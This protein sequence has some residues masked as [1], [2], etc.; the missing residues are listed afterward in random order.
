MSILYIS[1]DGMLEPLGQSQVLSYL[2]SLSLDYTI[3]LISFEKPHDLLKTVELDN[4]SLDILNSGIIWHRLTYHKSPSVL[5]TLWDIICGASLGLF[6]TIRFDLKIIHSRSYVPSVMALIIKRFTKIKYIFDMRGFWVDER[7][8]GGLWNRKS[9]LFKIAKFF[10]K[11]FLL[12]ADHVVS[13]T[14]AAVYEIENFS[15]L[16]NKT[17]K[18]STI[19]TC[20]NLNL[21][22]IVGN[23][24]TDKSFT[25]G[26][27]GSVGT[28]YL[29]EYVLL[30]FKILLVIMPNARLCIV[31]KG[32]HKYINELLR[33]ESFPEGSI[34]LISSKHIE[35]PLL[36]SQ[37][38]AGIFFI[39]PLFSKQ[40]SAPTKLA[41]FLGC[42]IPC[43]T[44]SGIG[45]M[46]YILESNNV[47]ISISNFDD[48]SIKKGLENLLKL[49]NEAD[50]NKRCRETALNY[51]SLTDGVLAYKKIYDSLLISNNND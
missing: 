13:L 35:I 4:L 47:G 20:A 14:N 22:N 42:G 12:S 15:Y 44:N 51:F 29:F 37:M 2:N 5:A 19:P 38:D 23:K 21:F 30:A 1:Y 36:M 8:D 25:I 43:L 50:I 9:S 11:K 49:C 6:L 16:N 24:R 17:L 18:I 3:H 48:E 27:V 28:W 33:I 41:E 40:A 31:N 46:S 45:D 39:K 34:R 7:V 26:Y 32:E 10:E